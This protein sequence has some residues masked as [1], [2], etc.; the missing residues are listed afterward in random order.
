MILNL[1][2]FLYLFLPS[3]QM[4]LG[5]PQLQPQKGDA[6]PSSIRQLD[7]QVE[8][9]GFLAETTITLEITDP[10]QIRQE[11]SFLLQLPAHSVVDGF[12][13]GIGE[14]MV[15]GVIQEKHL[16]RIGFD[17]EKRK[18]VDPG[19]IESV[20]H[21]LYR[22]R[23]FPISAS[24]PRKLSLRYLAPLS[25]QG[26]ADA[27]TLDLSGIDSKTKV[28]VSFLQRN[29]IAPPQ[30][31]GMESGTFE[32]GE[33][34]FGWHLSATGPFRHQLDF[35]WQAGDRSS[36]MIA[37]DDDLWHY[38]LRSKTAEKSGAAYARPATVAVFWDASNARNTMT[39]NR[40]LEALSRLIAF[41]NPSS[42]V[43]IPFRDRPEQ[44][45]TFPNTR[46]GK[47]ELEKV[48][49]NMVYD[50]GTNLH[51]L[52]LPD[53]LHADEVWIFTDGHDTLGFPS[54][55]RHGAV[56]VFAFS[57]SP[58]AQ[59]PYLEH[60]CRTNG[61]QALF[62]SDI[63]EQ[64]LHRF[65]RKSESLPDTLAT[66]DGALPESWISHSPATRTLFAAGEIAS[67]PEGFF[68][69][70]GTTRQK[71]I[72]TVADL[73]KNAE[74]A[75]WLT[76]FAAGRRLELLQL[77]AD[78]QREAILELGETHG[79]V[80]PHTSLIVFE[81]PQQY[82]ANGLVPPANAPFDV[83]KMPDMAPTKEALA[84]LKK[85]YFKGVARKWAT[86]NGENSDWLIT[87]LKSS[88]DPWSVLDTIPGIQADTTNLGGNEAQSESGSQSNFVSPGQEGATASYIDSGSFSES[89]ETTEHMVVGAPMPT[90][91]TVS[92][93]TASVLP[94]EVYSDDSD[95]PDEI[96]DEGSGG[97]LVASSILNWSQVQA[98]VEEV[99]TSD[100]NPY[101][102]YLAFKAKYGGSPSFYYQVAH[103]FSEIGQPELAR[104]IA[105]NLLEQ[106]WQDDR[107]LFAA[108]MLCHVLEDLDL[109]EVLYQKLAQNRPEWPQARM[110][111]AQIQRE[112][113]IG[114]EKS[115]P[116][117]AIHFYRRA[118]DLYQDLALAPWGRLDEWDQADFLEENRFPYI[119]I[120]VVEEAFWIQMRLATLGEK[121]QLQLP[122]GFEATPE[123]IKADL[124]VLLWWDDE[125]ADLDLWVTEPGDVLVNYDTNPAAG[126]GRILDQIEGLGPDIYRQKGGRY[127]TFTVQAKFYSTVFSQLLGPVYAKAE[128]WT[129][130]GYPDEA[131]R[132]E[133]HRMDGATTMEPIQLDEVTWPPE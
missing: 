67:R 126:S 48:L 29:G 109:A 47:G 130:F 93:G 17:R 5:V 74:A 16:A 119:P 18:R 53:D 114:F 40:E 32:R 50:G 60:F 54:K 27:Y 86:Y 69:R 75:S 33:N 62:W 131:Y 59:W 19:L 35:H 80:T 24:M 118:F 125:N 106:G 112:K 92:T 21:N 73:S 41:R 68:L 43:L 64:K 2:S 113:A 25:R 117:A 72:G 91:E 110:L 77:E 65:F 55:T 14:T 30:L 129:R 81:T 78:H 51:G 71:V 82:A 87:K 61:G 116:K 10:D 88:K 56:P 102:T 123:D 97:E 83:S 6:N 103:H 100:Q 23:V 34:G 107:L 111:V 96:V 70:N 105:T 76:R 90:N 22:V 66:S 108:G 99:R 36:V 13:L 45:K 84:E 104:R 11:A 133:I 4:P 79:F 15:D 120:T 63:S 31:K 95:I 38:A 98:A 115:D 1:L 28:T 20:G 42:I 8:V 44:P 46:L 37:V 9:L 89:G 128:M 3:N 124:R 52:D 121:V 127:G 132:V 57:A 85:I 101:E 122:P 12:Q 94:V 26:G 49:A 58:Q 39:V 7:Y